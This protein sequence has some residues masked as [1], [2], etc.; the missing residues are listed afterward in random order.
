MPFPGARL[1][2]RKGLM[3]RERPPEKGG[4]GVHMPTLPDADPG[5]PKGGL[6]HT[7]AFHGAAAALRRPCRNYKTAS[8]IRKLWRAH[9]NDVS[10]HMHPDV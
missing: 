6:P 3:D 8:H 1:P 7:A 5:I 4:M 10:A 9:R 2:S